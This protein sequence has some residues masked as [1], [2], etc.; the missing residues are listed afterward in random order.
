M[1]TCTR[2][3]LAWPD[4]NVGGMEPMSCYLKELGIRD[5]GSGSSDGG[6]EQEDDGAEDDEHS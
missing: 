4:W 6:E 5:W 2:N 1:E 3:S